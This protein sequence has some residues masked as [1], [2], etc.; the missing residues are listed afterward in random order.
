MSDKYEARTPADREAVGGR[1]IPV[2]SARARLAA[3]LY[4]MQTQTWL[5][6]PE[7]KADF[8]LTRGVTV[9][10]PAPAGSAP[11]RS[12]AEMAREQGFDD[13]ASFRGQRRISNELRRASVGSPRAAAPDGPWRFFKRGPNKYGGYLWSVTDNIRTYEH[14]DT[15]AEAITVRDAL[16]ALAG[17]S[18]PAGGDPI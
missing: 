15:E 10:A 14:F 13:E 1:D 16:N 4:E 6:S 3:L 5:C 2:G 18:A 17:R 8:L 9:G 12:V 11:N 7:V